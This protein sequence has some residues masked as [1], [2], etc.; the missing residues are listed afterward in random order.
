MRSSSRKINILFF[1]T[2]FVLITG[3]C[4]PGHAE[5]AV[6]IKNIRGIYYLVDINLEA[7]THYEVGQQYAEQIRANV[8][9]YEARIDS[10]LSFMQKTLKIDLETLKTRAM[11]ISKNIP[12]EYMDEIKGLQS[13]F[14]YTQDQLG[15]GRLSQNE[16]LIFE[17]FGDVARL[18]GCSASAVFGN[19]SSTGNTI[20]ERNL[21]W[22][23]LPNSELQAIHAVVKIRNKDKSLVSFA[24]LGDVAF[25]SAVS[26]NNIFAALLDVTTDKPYP[27]TAGKRSYMM[28]LRYALENMT[29]LKEVA[30]YMSNKDYAYSHIIFL[31]DKNSS[32]VLENDIGSPSRGLRSASSALQHGLTWDHP[33]AIVTVNSFLLPGN[34]DTHTRSVDVDRWNSFS[35]LY[36]KFLSDNSKMDV[37]E[38]KQIAGYYGKDGTHATGALFRPADHYPSMHLIIMRMDT[39][40]TWVAFAP[41]GAQPTKPKYIKVFGKNP[42]H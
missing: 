31:A 35:S 40:E 2:A 33:D 38:M 3:T 8:P 4:S 12:P 30:D 14:S 42:F 22:F 15:D 27:P 39:L 17:I 21:E 28:D 29:T 16:L 41:T 34:S 37:D 18:S 9:N 36:G 24:F 25:I 11:D 13:V 32:F 5:Q 7:A 19:S 1:I 23:E 20:V 26:D 6:T 10:F